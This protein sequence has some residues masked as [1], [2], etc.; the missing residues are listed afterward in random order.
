MSSPR[1]LSGETLTAN[2]YRLG[3]YLFVDWLDFVLS[4]RTVLQ[5]AR[6]LPVPISWLHPITPSP[7]RSIVSYLMAC[8]DLVLH[9]CKIHQP[10]LSFKPYCVILLSINSSQ[11]FLS[12]DIMSKRICAC[13]CKRL[14]LESIERHHQD[15][16][17]PWTLTLH[18]LSANPW[19]KSLAK[20]NITKATH[21]K[22]K[23]RWNSY[24]DVY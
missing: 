6:F 7:H 1:R 8:L 20:K 11:S 5:S 24:I 3:I 4:V 17:G 21:C 18:V 15:S 19:V 14:I 16:Q 13:G 9:L 10:E 23:S 12:S 2:E 22:P